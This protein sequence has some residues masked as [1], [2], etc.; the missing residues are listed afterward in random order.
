MKINPIIPIWVMSLLCVLFLV[1]GRKGK[2]NYI[3][4]VIIVALLFAINLRPWS[5]L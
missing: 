2:F 3:R 5:S 4:Q 1:L